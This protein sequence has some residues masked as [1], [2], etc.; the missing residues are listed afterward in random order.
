MWKIRF[1]FVQNDAVKSKSLLNIHWWVFFST[2]TEQRFDIDSRRDRIRLGEGSDLLRGG[3]LR[4]HPHFVARTHE[5]T[6]HEYTFHTWIYLKIPINI[7]SDYK[8]WNYTFHSI[9]TNA[10]SIPY[11]IIL[12][13]QYL[14]YGRSFSCLVIWRTISHTTIDF[15]YMNRSHQT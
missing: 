9:P 3:L 10:F 5:Y 1:F 7:I 15:S 8:Q 6:S 4:V 2:A 11:S 14:R 12:R 13:A